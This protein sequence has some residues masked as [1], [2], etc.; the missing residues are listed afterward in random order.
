MSPGPQTGACGKTRLV[1]VGVN[2]GSL[3]ALCAPTSHDGNI[4]IR[5]EC[6]FVRGV[7]TSALYI[8][9]VCTSFVCGAWGWWVQCAVRG[10]DRECNQ[11]S[12][13]TQTQEASLYQTE[14]QQ[15]KPPGRRLLG[16]LGKVLPAAGLALGTRR[17][18]CWSSFPDCAPRLLRCHPI[19]VLMDVLGRPR[20][21]LALHFHRLPELQRSWLA[22]SGT[23]SGFTAAQDSKKVPPSA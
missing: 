9:C 3:C 2:P 7:F 13:R 19:T 17:H 18:S 21:P 10:T 23:C 11:T 1:H 6:G 22:R 20:D 16:E 5:K 15:R 8:V 12:T 4:F 14:I